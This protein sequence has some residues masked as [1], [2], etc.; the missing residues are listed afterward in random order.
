MGGESGAAARAEW[1]RR[2]TLAWVTGVRPQ[3]PHPTLGTIRPEPYLYQGALW[4]DRSA[5]RVVLKA[6]QTGF[7]QAIAFEALHT[8]L[9]QAGATVLVVSRNLE[10][11]INVLGYVKTALETPG[12]QAPRVVKNNETQLGLA[13]RSRIVSIPATKGAGR[14][15]AATAVYLDEFAWMPWATDIYT[16]VAPTTS[17]GGRLTVLSTPNGRANAFYLLWMGHWG[18][19]FSRHRAP[20]YRCPA[21]N[22]DGWSVG[23]EHGGTE[24]SGGAEHGDAEGISGERRA[25]EIG[26]RGAWFKAQRPK[27]TSETWAQEY[28]CDF[29]ESG[30][31]AF[32][33]EDVERAQQ[34]A[35]GLEPYRSGREY[36]TF[37]D[38]GRRGDATVG[39][40]LDVSE[41]PLQVVG[42]ERFERLPYPA[43]QRRIEER[44]RA[45]PGQ[46]WVES[47][48]PGDPV[49]EN[50][51]VPVQPWVTSARSKTQMIEALVLALEGGRLGWPESLRELTAEM[52]L[53]QWDDERLVQD[54]VM[55]LAGAVAVV[56]APVEAVE[57]VVYD[58]RVR[59]SPV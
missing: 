56:G 9:H 43:I 25:R 18:K 30:Q 6:R 19:A 38:I 14:T 17:R 35:R 37:W 36:V 7:S 33:G 28:D 20:W 53:Y 15:Y 41:W 50:L 49:I 3:L 55:S 40:T 54:C 59:I 27:Y 2:S 21:Y 42:W 47:N 39:T 16:A 5:T 13:N 46:H 11:A 24:R 4:S 58:E 22:P 51:A 29:I 32:K 34:I 26:E 23:L 12:L 1:E 10:A 44:F 48:G 57:T 8:V 45:Y 52:T 31:A